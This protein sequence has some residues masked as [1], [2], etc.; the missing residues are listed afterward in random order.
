MIRS[1]KYLITYRSLLIL[2]MFFGISKPIKAQV[3]IGHLNP[4]PSAQLDLASDSLGFLLPR[5]T[6]DKMSSI[7]TPANGLVV[8]CTNSLPSPGFYVYQNNKWERFGHV[9]ST[10]DAFANAS[11]S[12]VPSQKAIKNYFDNKKGLKLLSA[13]N[14]N[15]TGNNLNLTSGSFSGS[16]NTALGYAS[17]RL[18][19]SGG[20]NTA[21]GY[22]TSPN[23][24]SGSYNTAFGSHSLLNN[25]TGGN[26]VAMGYY[27]LAIGSSPANNVAIG[28]QAGRNINGIYNTA[29]GF[30]AANGN[31]IIKN[32][33]Y[34]TAI[35]GRSGFESNT[36]R[37]VYL[38]FEAGYYDTINANRQ[39][40]FIENSQ[41]LQ[42]LIGG[43]FVN[44]RV[45]INTHIDS[46][47]RDGSATL[48]IGG[49][50]SLQNDLVIDSF[51]QVITTGRAD[52]VPTEKAVKAYV[53]NNAIQDLSISGNNLSLSN[54]PTSTPIDLS[55]YLDNTDSQTINR[56]AGS[57]TVTLS[58]GSGA[59]T[60][61]TDS[62][63]NLGNH[64]AIKNLK[65]GEYK[66]VGRGAEGLSISQD[67]R[68]FLTHG[69]S[70]NEFSN[71]GTF[72]D[73]SRSAVPTELAVV[74]YVGG[75]FDSVSNKID[76]LKGLGFLDHGYNNTSGNT[77]NF[78]QIKL[79][80]TP[81][82]IARN[83]LA[84]GNGALKLVSS[85]SG[86]IAVGHNSLKK[87]QN[88]AFNTVLGTDAGLNNNDSG[89]VFIGHKAGLNETTGHKLY[90]ESSLSA[91]ADGIPLI[92]GD[93][94]EDKVG[95][96]IA[97]ND[98]KS[99]DASLQVNGDIELKELENGAG[100]IMTSKGGVRWKIT[101]DDNGSWIKTKL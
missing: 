63:D 74:N 65:L 66:L 38:G 80:G 17:L 86:N 40:L 92:G 90:I 30:G 71:D 59:N 7:N 29:V 91:N 16:A 93:F 49:S 99:S 6:W 15:V 52:V 32:H 44:N 94:H 82:L 13:G 89:N 3:A 12:L 24:T 78:A 54:D 26:N 47:H 70:I 57:K 56:P 37:S 101:I 18:V 14:G 23:Q 34:T 11:D 42:P 53:D 33:N 83:N 76:S 51:A 45:G 81:S 19:T 20:D 50:I 43:D 72:A 21:A 87:L 36:S 55:P 48:Q 85:G 97:V 75:F 95:I 10:D 79:S 98:L 100:I 69:D 67:G 35:G 8:Y 9:I 31:G 39:T 28:N 27:A 2:I 4:D 58:N 46:I 62:T 77:N 68:I 73:S 64:T 88:G 25:T 5:M 1:K 22:N 60:T 84:L 96:N 41:S 61:F